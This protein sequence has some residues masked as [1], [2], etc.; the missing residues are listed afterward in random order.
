MDIVKKLRK[1][2]EAI[3][4]ASMEV[5]NSS[6]DK[7]FPG[8]RK[9]LAATARNESAVKSLLETCRVYADAF[10]ERIPIKTVS[11]K[12]K[13]RKVKRAYSYLV[14]VGTLACIDSSYVARSKLTAFCL[15]YA[16]RVAQNK[17]VCIVQ[18]R[19]R[20]IAEEEAQNATRKELL[21][22]FG[23]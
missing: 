23:S 1:A 15:A 13:P 18:G 7:K 20:V 4:L 9:G 3:F 2:K 11:L 6:E 19:V 10:N 17:P 12:Y 8:M 5:Y 16:L 22:R 21:G 14:I